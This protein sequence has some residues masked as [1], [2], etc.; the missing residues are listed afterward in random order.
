MSCDLGSSEEAWELPSEEHV[1][2]HTLAMR[3]ALQHCQKLLASA[4]WHAPS[5][6]DATVLMK[7][8]EAAARSISTLRNQTLRAMKTSDG[9]GVDPSKVVTVVDKMMSPCDFR[10]TFCHANR[11]CKIR[12]SD[13]CQAHFS[14]ALE[15]WR[16]QTTTSSTGSSI[17]RSWFEKHLGERNTMLPVRYQTTTNGSDEADNIDE[18]GRAVECE[19]R[20]MSL[21][22][23]VETLDSALNNDAALASNY[24]KD[25]HLQKWLEDHFSSEEAALYLVPVQFQTD[26]LNNLLL[27]FTKGDYRFTYWGPAGSKTGLH[28]DVLNSFSWSFNVCGTKEWTFFVPTCAS[29]TRRTVISS[30]VND[31]NHVGQFT[32]VTIRQQAGECIF[33]PAGW[34][35]QVVNIDETLSINH[36]WITTAN[37]D[38]TW[39][40][41]L[42]EIQAV[43][44]ELLA[45]STS[46]ATDWGAK[47]SML[48][49]CIGL[50]VTAFLFMVLLGL[51][52]ELQCT[53][54]PNWEHYFDMVR[55]RDVLNDLLLD[56]EIHLLD[57]LQATLDS[58]N[59]GRAAVAT[60]KQT[61][62][63]AVASDQSTL[64]RT[65]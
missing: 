40:C 41:M 10:R 17:N 21:A 45:W 38:L 22:Q 50:D 7:Q 31:K 53:D 20:N 48:R 5:S 27:R 4:G 51:L 43:D 13:W 6:N 2:E 46:N 39:Q 49:G 14:R 55:L 11:P 33:V 35:H 28:S 24:L 60:V 29:D 34:K 58:E 3:K 1:P 61:L 37:V 26:L 64:V 63:K 59:L 62:A 54:E 16:K 18:D 9:V 12:D 32:T 36:N 52:E 47:E 42:S 57:R 65:A 25:W 19:I 8:A 44:Q 30:A 15:C 23:W 56:P